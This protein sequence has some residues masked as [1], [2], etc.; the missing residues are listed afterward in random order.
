MHEYARTYSNIEKWREWSVSVGKTKT[1]RKILFLCSFSVMICFSA[2][3]FRNRVK[4]IFM[5]KFCFY[6][7]DRSKGSKCDFRKRQVDPSVTSR[8]SFDFICARYA[9]WQCGQCPLLAYSKFNNHYLC[10][11]FIIWY[12]I[13]K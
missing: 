12:Q 1:K 7:L 2:I 13:K 10:T 9:K 6:C 5:R 3:S 4:I 8:F 11:T